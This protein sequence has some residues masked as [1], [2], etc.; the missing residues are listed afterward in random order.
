MVEKK[1]PLCIAG[2]NA[3]W[4]TL[5]GNSMTVPEKLEIELSLLF[6][7]STLAFLS[8][9]NKRYMHFHF[10][11]NIIYNNQDTEAM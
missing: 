1:E 11:R 6:S 9:E 8:E 4:C 2:G 3:N 7:N 5:M 10:H